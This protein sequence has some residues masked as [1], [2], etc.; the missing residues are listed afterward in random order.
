L[1]QPRDT[2]RANPH[3]SLSFCIAFKN[4]RYEPSLEN[5]GNFHKVIL[6]IIGRNLLHF[7]SWQL[8][9]LKFNQPGNTK[10]FFDFLPDFTRRFVKIY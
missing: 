1:V 10:G 2:S 9:V 6:I 7:S 5:H 4:P 8:A 3:A